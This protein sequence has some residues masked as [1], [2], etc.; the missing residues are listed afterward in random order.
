MR[1]IY[2][3]RHGETD[4]VKEGRIQGRQ[5][6]PLNEKGL[7]QARIISNYFKDK[8]IAVIVT[9][10]L[11]RSIQT[12]EI[13]HNK[14]PSASF[15]KISAFDE[16]NYGLW[17][18][19]LWSEIHNEIPNLNDLWIKEG[20]T[21]RPPKGESVNEFIKRVRSSFKK[22]LEKYPEQNIV[23]AIHGGSIKM[24]LGLMKDISEEEFYTQKFINP[25]DLQ[26]VKEHNGV[27]TIGENVTIFY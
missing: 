23:I 7:E 3:V 5:N 2:L 9:S 10:N 14:I 19:R 11:T 20:L 15:L 8:N 16:K 24:I 1:N 18:N 12:G 25:G 6:V 22:L 26:I 27:F 13:I 4:Y 21:F 17:Q